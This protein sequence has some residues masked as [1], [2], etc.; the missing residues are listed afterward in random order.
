MISGK[1]RVRKNPEV[2]RK[3]YGTFQVEQ[4]NHLE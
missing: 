2:L 3:C 1:M 4:V